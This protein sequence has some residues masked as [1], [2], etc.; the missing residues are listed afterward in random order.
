MRKSNARNRCSQPK[1]QHKGVANR[2]AEANKDTRTR[3]TL[4]GAWP[5]SQMCRKRLNW[6]HTCLGLELDIFSDFT[7]IIPTDTVY[8]LMNDVVGAEL[9]TMSTL[10][11][12]ST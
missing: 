2:L 10:L 5:L 7:L 4:K 8:L 1:A 6:R 11:N 3:E 9:P 12:T